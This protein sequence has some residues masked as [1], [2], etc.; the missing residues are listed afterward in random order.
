MERR[1]LV[2]LEH[3]LFVGEGEIGA[4]FWVM[5]QRFHWTGLRVGLVERMERRS[6]RGL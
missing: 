4:A 2:L 5:D 3:R 6:S 1:V